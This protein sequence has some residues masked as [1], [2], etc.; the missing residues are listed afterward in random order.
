MAKKRANEEGSIRKR[1]DGRWEAGTP[2]DTTPR[3]ANASTRMCWAGP[4]QRSGKN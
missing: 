3:P 4:R 2:P 1:S